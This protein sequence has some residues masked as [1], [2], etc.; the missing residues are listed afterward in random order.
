MKVKAAPGLL[1][2][3]EFDPRTYV[4]DKDAV[5]VPETP[6]Y[7]RRMAAGELVDAEAPAK[8]VKASAKGKDEAQ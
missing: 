5:D 6:Y 1:V 2:P 7:I 8:A 4:D 3:H